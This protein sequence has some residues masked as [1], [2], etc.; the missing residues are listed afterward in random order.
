MPAP[1]VALSHW[2][3]PAL[4]PEAGSQACSSGTSTCGR[5][6]ARSPD[7]TCASVNAGLTDHISA[8]MPPTAGA[9]KLVPLA[10]A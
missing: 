7:S 5:A 2:Q 9:A 4:L 8:A 6:E 3:R 10:A 1:Q